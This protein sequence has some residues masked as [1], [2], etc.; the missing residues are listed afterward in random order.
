VDRYVDVTQHD[1]TEMT[2][3]LA[4]ELGISVGMSAGGATWA[5]V[6]VARGL[7]SG[8]VVC[9]LCDRGDRYL[10]SGLFEGATR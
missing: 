5:A 6:E 8:V 10:S 7:D 9:I 3:R 4:K 1:A 2:R